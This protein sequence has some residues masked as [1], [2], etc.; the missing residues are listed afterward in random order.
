MNKSALRSKQKNL[1][2]VLDYVIKNGEVSR[3]E[4]ARA[5]GI[6]TATVTNLVTELIN[7]R[8]LYESRLKHAPVGRKTTMLRFSADLR[9]IV[10][11]FL[12]N[13]KSIDLAVCNLLGEPLVT[14][15]V[16][17]S[18][19]IT[20]DRTEIVVLRD[21]I[22]T[23]KSFINSQPIDLFNSIVAIGI[24]VGGMVNIKQTIDM[25]Q[26]NWKNVNLVAPLQ[27]EM[28][29]PVYCEGVTRMKA[30][31]EL[32]YIDPDEQNVI[33]LN[34]S[35][36]IGIA[37]FFNGHIIQGHTGIAGEAGHISLNLHG[38]ECY[39]GNRG[40]FEIYCGMYQ[41]LSRA[42]LLI[43]HK[44]KS[45]IFYD[46]VVNNG[47]P[48]TARTLFEALNRGS[49]VVHELLSEVSEYLGSALASLYNIFDPNRIIVSAY[50]D[51]D[52]SFVLDNAIAEAKSRIIN[53]FSRQL[54]IT[55]AHLKIE[56]THLGIC[57][58]VLKKLLDEMFL[59]DTK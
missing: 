45:D 5:F 22:Q 18:F 47:A 27:A 7:L 52:D 58:Y 21:I 1:R 33:Y 29:M 38:P 14:K 50:L 19:D 15:K 20:E 32:R 51:D 57:A 35:T 23:I 16:D 9:L 46:M 6:S 28:H 31:Y 39:C 48:M 53:R 41:I 3:V 12:S 59:E 56:E 24:C 8:L 36:G 43:H 30:Q 25:P 37:N 42:S 40:C 49:L 44:N 2:R 4:I 54:N 17:I 26:A 34:L 10:T 11:V 55:R 13:R